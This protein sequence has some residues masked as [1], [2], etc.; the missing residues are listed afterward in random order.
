MRTIGA[1]HLALVARVAGSVR[2][3]QQSA[4][5][6]LTLQ[7]FF[8]L[9]NIFISPESNLALLTYCH[10]LWRRDLTLSNPVLKSNATHA[11]FLSRL[12]G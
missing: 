4:L 6:L 11:Q 5:D 10:G 3:G 1:T 8:H 9:L 7:L 2:Q 12:P